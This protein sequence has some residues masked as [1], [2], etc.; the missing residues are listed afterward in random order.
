MRVLRNIDVIVLA[1]ALPV[2]VVAQLPILGY[3]AT[4]VAWLAA[5]WF[6]AFVERRALAKGNRKAA[7][8][9]RAASL[10]GRL[11]LVTIAVFLAGLIDRHA[12]VAG[13]V[14]A[15]VVFTSYFVS[16]FVTAALE[17]D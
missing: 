17:N 7:L 2:F 13:G 8:G 10:L 16:L 12:G 14:L 3:A 4:T 5:R 1:V 6:Q 15:A 9:A 11:Y